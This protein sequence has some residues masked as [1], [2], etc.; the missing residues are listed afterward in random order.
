MSRPGELAEEI[1]RRSAEIDRW[2]DWAQPYEPLTDSRP[3]AREAA[4]E[5][6]AD[7][8]MS[9][10]LDADGAASIAPPTE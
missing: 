1:R 10:T 8:R 5:S 2:P 7:H 9:R 6:A 3:A 4:G